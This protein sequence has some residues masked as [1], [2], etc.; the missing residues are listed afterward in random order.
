MRM[1]MVDPKF[2]CV[3]HLN[4]EHLEIHMFLGTLKDRKS[5]KG[6][7]QK[8]LCQPRSFKTRHDSIVEEM[9]SRGYKGHKTD[10]QDTDCS[11]VCDLPT[12]YQYWEVDK[13]KSLA[14]LVSRCPDCL[15][16]YEKNVSDPEKERI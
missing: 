11:C 10:I 5:I 16:R 12:E 2:M 1:W 4:G 3:K 7:I 14:D 15:K 6:Y 8:N 13:V 9:K